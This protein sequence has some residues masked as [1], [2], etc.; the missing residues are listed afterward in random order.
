MLLTMRFRVKAFEFCNMKG[1]VGSFGFLSY[2]HIYMV[3]ENVSTVTNPAFDLR[4]LRRS[5]ILK[6]LPYNIISY[7][8]QRTCLDGVNPQYSI[9]FFHAIL[10]TTA[11]MM[12][13]SVRR[14][15]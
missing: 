10:P 12:N 11:M 8:D 3:V 7:V 15:D 4:P 2:K 1:V 5:R 9:V 6:L 13:L 14:T